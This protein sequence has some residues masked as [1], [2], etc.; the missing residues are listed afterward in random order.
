MFHQK[1]NRDFYLQDAFEVTKKLLGAYLCTCIDGKITV[2]KIV[3]TE[4][5][6]GGIDKASHSYKGKRTK[7]TEIQFGIGGH[8]YIF[9]VY[10]MYSQFCVVTGPENISDV[11]LVR[12]LEPIEGLEL[13]QARRKPQ[14]KK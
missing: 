4:A 5:Y 9:L 7:R 12:A 6:I 8:A 2:G 1:L 11:V 3:E 10:G 14:K 13:M